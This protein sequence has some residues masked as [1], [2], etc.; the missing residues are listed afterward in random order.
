[1]RVLTARGL[2]GCLNHP[3]SRAYAGLQTS[4]SGPANVPAADERHV[5]V[6]LKYYEV[7]AEWAWEYPNGTVDKVCKQRW[8]IQE[9]GIYNPGNGWAY[10]RW[11]GKSIL[12][13]DGRISVRRSR[14]WRNVRYRS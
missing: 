3:A 7:S 6:S 1:V 12:Y 10:I 9:G 11:D 8:F 5:Q 2:A 14:Q 13:Q 4:E